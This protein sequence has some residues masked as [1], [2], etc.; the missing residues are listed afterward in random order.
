MLDD[1]PAAMN[2]T[3]SE[4]EGFS[5]QQRIRS[6]SLMGS[7]RASIRFASKLAFSTKKKC[8]K[9]RP[10]CKKPLMPR[11]TTTTTPTLPLRRDS[12]CRTTAVLAASL[13]QRCDPEY[14]EYLWQVTDGHK[15]PFC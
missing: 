6:S 13:T 5:R 1:I 8:T 4:A 14:L 11:T 7:M 3:T 15:R 10:A 2:L 12:P 9:R